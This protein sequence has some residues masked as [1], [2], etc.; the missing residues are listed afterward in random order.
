MSYFRFMSMNE[1][2]KLTSGMTLS[3]CKNSFK[4]RTESVGFCFLNSVEFSVEYSHM[5]LVG[6]V[7]D[8]VVVEFECNTELTESVGIYANPC[9]NYYD[10]MTVK[11]YC[12]RSY[13]R[14][15]MK[16][17]RYGFVTFGKVTWYDFN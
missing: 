14:D 10:I 8:D 6:I 16:P 4:A 2:Q 12:V 13:S 3:H 5:F 9:G 11:E 15:T 7:S 1:F 17:I